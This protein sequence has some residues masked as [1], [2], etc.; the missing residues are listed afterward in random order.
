ML[1]PRGLQRVQGYPSCTL[2]AVSRILLPQTRHGKVRTPAHHTAAALIGSIQNSCSGGRAAQETPRE[3]AFG[4]VHCL[5]FKV[6]LAV[7]GVGEL[8]RSTQLLETSDT[9]LYCLSMGH[10]LL[11]L[12]CSSLGPAWTYDWLIP[13]SLVAATRT[14]LLSHLGTPPQL[15]CCGQPTNGTQPLQIDREAMLLGSHLSPHILHAIGGLQN[16]CG[17]PPIEGYAM[18]FL[19]QRPC[20]DWPQ[21]YAQII[22][23]SQNSRHGSCLQCT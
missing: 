1:R 7:C 14:T 11:K 12:P 10:I 20:H 22:G 21:A 13:E 5:W 17:C 6:R 4:G 19:L 18:A 23:Q 2:L 3:F 16:F 8:S 15:Q 9:G